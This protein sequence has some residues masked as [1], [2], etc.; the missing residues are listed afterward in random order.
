MTIPCSVYIITL[1]EEQHIRR[2]LESV[3]DFVEV[4][5]V[6]SG[7]VDKTLDIAK[8]YGAQLSY[9]PFVSFS[10]Q[11]SHALSLCT[12]PWVLNIDADEQV[13]RQLKNDITA[14]IESNKCDALKIPIEDMFLGMPPH[15]LGKKHSK[16]RF[17]RREKGTYAANLVH[18]G[19]S[20]DGVVQQVSGSIVHYGETSIEVKVTKNN[21]YSSLR[22]KEKH[23]KDKKPSIFKLVLVFP[24]TLIKSF[25]FRRNFLNGRR[26]FIGSMINAFY[27]FLKEAKLFEAVLESE[28]TID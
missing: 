3:K 12:Q 6:D 7:S 21:L 16:V 5:V 9:H 22:A 13:S 18:E 26:G 15:K 10:Q 4:I 1:N 28:K 25:L 19:V 27:A 24:A 23:A 8:E 11:K 14:C 2:A 17:F 20:I